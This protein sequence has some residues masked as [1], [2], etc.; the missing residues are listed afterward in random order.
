MKSAPGFAAEKA[1]YR[2]SEQYRLSHSYSNYADAQMIF[3]QQLIST[4]GLGVNCSGTDGSNCYCGGAGCKQA[5][6]TCCC[7][8]DQKCIDKTGPRVFGSVFSQ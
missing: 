7:L 6:G 5:G 3:S 1:L 2:T 4:G 8:N